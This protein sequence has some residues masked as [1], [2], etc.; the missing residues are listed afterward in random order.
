[1]KNLK[2]RRLERGFTCESLG[3]LINVQKSA[4]SKYERG[5]I[6]PSKEVLIKIAEVLDCTTDFL[7]DIT[8]EPRPSGYGLIGERLKGLRK[9]RGLSQKEFAG[10]INV[11]QNT[12]SNWENENPKCP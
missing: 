11:A 1:M 4:V 3:K 7:L 10:R 12:V 2:K 5:E 9:D 6:Q 8:D